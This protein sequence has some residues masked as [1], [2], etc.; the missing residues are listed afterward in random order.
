MVWG[1]FLKGGLLLLQSPSPVVAGGGLLLSG[2]QM[3][4]Q[5][6]EMGIFSHIPRHT[7]AFVSLVTIAGDVCRCLA[8]LALTGG[9]E[10]TPD[11][12]ETLEEKE[13]PG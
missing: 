1:M 8:A 10:M 9:V 3:R 7:Q 13:K 2:Y 11:W 6:A 12:E 5:V 4:G